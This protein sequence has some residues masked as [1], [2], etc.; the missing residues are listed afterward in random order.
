MRVRRS[1]RRDG[2]S[3]A[4]AINVGESN[5][6][7]EVTSSQQVNIDQHGEQPAARRHD[8]TTDSEGADDGR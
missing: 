5:A 1:I 2:L 8:G 6:V 4:L 7:T 3:A